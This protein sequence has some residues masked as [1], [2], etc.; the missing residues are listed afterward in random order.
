MLTIAWDVDDVLNDLMRVWFE[1][2]WLSQHPACSLRYEDLRKNPPHGILSASLNEYLVSLDSFRFSGFYQEMK[3]AED[4]LRWFDKRGKKYR[5]IALT[6]VPRKASGISASWVFSHFGDW[7]RT[8]HFVPSKREN[9][10]IPSY[11]K[12]KIEYLDWLGNVDI[13]VD[14]NEENIQAAK[15]IGVAGILIP[16]PWNSVRGTVNESLRLLSKL[17]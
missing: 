15:K 2:E 1:K 10:N 16:R 3:P 9:E 17:F 13:L 12:D 14:D 6:S 5:H 8:F 4:I 7:I 11:E